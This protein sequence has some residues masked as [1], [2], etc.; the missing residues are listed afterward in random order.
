[1]VPVA[2]GA[3]RTRLPSC[4]T[5][6]TVPLPAAAAHIGRDKNGRVPAHLAIVLPGRGYGPLGPAL[7]LP[8]LA[9]EQSGAEVLEIQYPMVPPA[10]DPEA[11]GS[12]YRSVGDQ[13][14]AALSEMSPSRVT[15]IA[16]SLG[17]VVLA[18]LSVERSL[19]PSVSAIWLTPIFGREAVRT[20]AVGKHWP[21]L[22][23]AGEADQ[24]HEPEHHAGVAAAL[25]A[26][27]L[28]LPRADH[29]LEV[30]GDVMATLEGFRA[31]TETVLEFVS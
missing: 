20:G 3:G 17:T 14:D 31:L 18:S 22:L 5:S 7:R 2:G 30:P 8:R 23:V 27:S 29:S 28:V 21:S 1:M 12:L 6:N 19:P 13:V 11:W 10:D 4:L 9:V 15:F 16:K 26:G 24:M 25:A